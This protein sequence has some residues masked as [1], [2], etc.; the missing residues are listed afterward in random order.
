[1]TSIKQKII[2]KAIK[3]V[4]KSDPTERLFSFAELIEAQKE[5]RQRCYSIINYILNKNSHPL[6]SGDKKGIDYKKAYE[7]M[8]DFENSLIN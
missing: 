5:E 6:Y 8:E 2:N 3:V 4:K 1:M 7:E